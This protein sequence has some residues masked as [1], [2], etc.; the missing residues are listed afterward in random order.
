MKSLKKNVYS[1]TVTNILPFFIT[2]F[3][4]SLL[5][6]SGHFHPKLHANLRFLSKKILLPVT[7]FWTAFIPNTLLFV[8]PNTMYVFYMSGNRNEHLL[9]QTVMKSWCEM[10]LSRE[11]LLLFV[12]NNRFFFVSKTNKLLFSITHT[13]RYLIRI[14]FIKYVSALQRK[15]RANEKESG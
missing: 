10:S 9:G 12:I 3:I 6:S 5:R 1:H 8:I 14:N 11:K 13:L 15:K 7:I 2:M 4:F